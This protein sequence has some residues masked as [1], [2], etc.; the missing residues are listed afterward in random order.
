[1]NIPTNDLTS[2]IQLITDDDKIWNWVSLHGS[3]DLVVTQAAYFVDVFSQSIS[4]RIRIFNCSGFKI[5]ITSIQVGLDFARGASFHEDQA[6]VQPGSDSLLPGAQIEKLFVLT[7]TSCECFQISVRLSVGEVSSED[8][9]RRGH[10]PEGIKDSDSVDNFKLLQWKVGSIIQFEKVVV[11]ILAQLRPNGLAIQ[12]HRVTAQRFLH[13]WNSL[14]F[15]NSGRFKCAVP[16]LLCD[17]EGFVVESVKATCIQ[18]PTQRNIWHSMVDWIDSQRCGVMA[19][20]FVNVCGEALAVRLSFIPFRSLH[21]AGM[22]EIRS[23][24]PLFL[25][26][27]LSEGDTFLQSITGGALEFVDNSTS[28]LPVFDVPMLDAS[29]ERLNS[30]LQHQRA[31]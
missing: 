4:L 10:L 7:L 11:S 30:V 2:H 16:L 3:S 19:W 5:P 13:I 23:S 27:I 25:G 31:L 14:P 18:D 29:L 22:I 9:V 15:S 17:I 6:S 24:C 21:C 8:F 20:S 28:Y 26:T 1:M 12:G